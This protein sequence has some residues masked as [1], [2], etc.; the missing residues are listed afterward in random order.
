MAK[1]LKRYLSFFHG[2]EIRVFNVGEYRRRRLGAQLPSAFFD[3]ANPE[4]NQ[5]RNECAQACMNELKDFLFS[6]GVDGASD[7]QASPS[8][9][10]RHSVD[11]GRVAIFDATNT[12]RE[13]RE[14]ICQELK[15][16]KTI[17][18]ESICTDE[19]IIDRNIRE[20]KL[21]LPDYAH[22]DKNKAYHDFVRRISHYERVYEPMSEEHLSWIKLYNCG[23]KFTCQNIHG[24]L[25]TKI[26]QFLT[27]IHATT[28]SFYLTRHGQSQYNIDGK[29]G[30]DSSLSP[31]GDQYA[32]ALGKFVESH[33]FKN[34]K[35][36][37]CKARLWTSSL[38][39]TIRT[40]SCIPHPVLEDGWVQCSPRVYRCL[41]E[42]Y[43]GVCDGMSYKEI[44]EKYPEEYSLRK[45][46]KLGFR[47][48][49]GE[50]YLDVIS[51]LDPLVH[52]MESYHENLVIV[53]HQGI[54]RLLFA[55]FTGLPR[56]QAPYVSI[57]LNTVIKLTPRAYDTEVNKFTKD[58][59][60]LF[61]IPVTSRSA[62]SFEDSTERN[63]ALD[64][65]SY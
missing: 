31:A 52:E 43:A 38:H 21:G 58:E 4:L 14:W 41:D 19:E 59:F 15:G 46:D 36:D 56:D 32:V 28:R 51:R 61:D 45:Q 39:R 26:V 1:R 53:G 11:S 22:L 7:E 6:R 2:A 5:S 47:Y 12:T 54:L 29:I 9:L 64:P 34:E 60:A 24:F 33:V 18:I 50:S 57:P 3:H 65:P 55:Y 63:P 35:D 8:G 40:A 37:P 27:N 16:V 62:T 48:P 49:R 25:P 20:S 30:G 17:F 23:K 10:E 44:Q 42:I 13:R